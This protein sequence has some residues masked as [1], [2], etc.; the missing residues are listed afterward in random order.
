[1]KYHS[2]TFR[3]L[4]CQRLQ[5]DEIWG[6]CNSKEKNV[7]ES[8]KGEFGIGDVWTWTPICADTKLIPTWL[9]GSRDGECARRFVTDL[10]GRLANRVQITTDGLEVLHR[11]C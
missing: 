6:F 11:S 3:N 8:R 10:A 5:L 7:P 2:A 1:M 4:P 9:I